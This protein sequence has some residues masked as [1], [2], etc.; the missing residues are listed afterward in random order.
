MDLT[1]FLFCKLLSYYSHGSGIK[2]SLPFLQRIIQ[3]LIQVLQV[4]ILFYLKKQVIPTYI[5]YCR[6]L[7][8]HGV[9]FIFEEG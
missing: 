4:L 6:P 3:V 9:H 8:P 1:A 7:I 2:T 5:N